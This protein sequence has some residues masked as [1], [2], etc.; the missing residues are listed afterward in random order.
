MHMQIESF[1]H[2]NYQSTVIC[3]LH[4]D[5]EGGLDDN[6]L[7]KIIFFLSGSTITSFLG[8]YS[9]TLLREMLLSLLLPHSLEMTSFSYLRY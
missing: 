3:F 1:W 4:C 9:P 8:S 7:E 6:I 5:V 2:F